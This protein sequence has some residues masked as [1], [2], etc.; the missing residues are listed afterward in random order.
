[1][2][3]NGVWIDNLEIHS[4]EYGVYNLSTRIQPL[5]KSSLNNRSRIDT[6][7]YNQKKIINCAKFHFFTKSEKKT[8]M[9]DFR[10]MS[11]CPLEHFFNRQS[12]QLGLWNYNS[13]S[14][15]ST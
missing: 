2:D 8:N 9:P 1:M 13:E 14:C 6:T 11:A 3:W 12:F 4:D 7:V 10:F 5:P 15:D